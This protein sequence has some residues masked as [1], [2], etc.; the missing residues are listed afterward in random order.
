MDLN[1]DMALNTLKMEMSIKESIRMED[2]KGEEDIL[3]VMEQCM[4][5]TFKM[6]WEMERVGGPQGLKMEISM[7]GNIVM[8]WSMDMEYIDG[9]TDQSM[10]EI[11]WKIKNMEMVYWLIKMGKYH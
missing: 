11:S 7:K 2:F 4:R 3:G 9:L 5:D 10:K 6:E 1:T 8:I